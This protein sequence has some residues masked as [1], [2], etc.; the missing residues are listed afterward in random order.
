MLKSLLY[1]EKRKERR[2]TAEIETD[3]DF[4]P[5][6]FHFLA[7]LFFFDLK[8][9]IKVES[10]KYS[11]HFIFRFPFQFFFT[12]IFFFP[13]IYQR[14]INRLF[15]FPVFHF[16]LRNCEKGLGRQ[17]GF[18]NWPP[19]SS[20]ERTRKSE[21]NANFGMFPAPRKFRQTFPK[22]RRREFARK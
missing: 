4:L 5:K 8:K 6:K 14:R 20:P 17:F 3:F 16:C 10:E 13:A 22:R 18:E 2:K 15:S 21:W 7:I 9:P 11:F 19:M 1:S 12:V